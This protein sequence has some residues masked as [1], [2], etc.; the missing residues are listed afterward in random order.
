MRR[1]GKHSL[2]DS[3]QKL[4]DSAGACQYLNVSRPTLSRLVKSR[5]LGCFRVGV[6]LLFSE[7]HLQEFLSR[8]EVKA[9]D[10]EAA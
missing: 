8:S 6:K 3:S 10:Q 1:G 9:L 2:A 4:Y 7:A 5:K